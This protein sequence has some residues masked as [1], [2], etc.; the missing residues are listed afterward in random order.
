MFGYH[1]ITIFFFFCS[2]KQCHKLMFYQPVCLNC[3]RS[4]ELSNELLH[5]IF[6]AA[7]L[8]KLLYASPFWWGF[9]TAQDKDRL[10]AFIR[11]AR[12]AGFYSKTSSF[13]EL[14]TSAD[15]KLFKSILGNSEH[16]LTPLLPPLNIHVHSTRRNVS[17]RNFLLPNK[18]TTLIDKNFITRM[19]LD[20]ARRPV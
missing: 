4:K 11:R 14:C 1:F 2:H 16:V 8:S 20:D 15:Q 7:T 3:L 6:Q 9:L 5:I 10:E 13:E 17:N 19:I 12:K 18:R